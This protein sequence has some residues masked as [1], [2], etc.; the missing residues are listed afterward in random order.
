MLLRNVMADEVDRKLIE[1]Y[2]GG[3]NDFPQGWCEVSAEE[4]AKSQLLSINV[5]FTE[6][7]QMLRPNEHTTGPCISANLSHFS[8]GGGYAIVSDYHSGRVRFYKF[9]CLDKLIELYGGLGALEDSGWLLN[10]STSSVHRGIRN[11][12]RIIRFDRELNDLEHKLLVTY[13]AAH[14]C[15]GWTG[16]SSSKVGTNRYSFSSTYDSSD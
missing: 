3:Y 6:Y 5:I 14:H 1:M 8:N 9:N 7:R 12:N 13:L 15:P 11:Y 4:F 2:S 10:E 16:I